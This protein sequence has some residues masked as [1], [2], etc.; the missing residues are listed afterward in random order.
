MKKQNNDQQKNNNKQQIQRQPK[1]NQRS[2]KGNSTNG[3][4]P[5]KYN[6]QFTQMK[7]PKVNQER[8]GCVIIKHKEY[9]T[10]INIVP[11]LNQSYYQ[12]GRYRLNPASTATFPWL[13]TIAQAFE[14]YRFRKLQFCYKP[15]C[16]STIDGA[17]IM[18]PDYDAADASP[19]SE[20]E[21]AMNMDSVEDSCS[22]TIRLNCSNAR[23][24]AAY[25]QHYTASDSRFFS[26]AQD[27]KTLDCGSVV[28]SV[29]S[30][31]T[32]AALLV[33]FGKLWVEYEV[34]L[35]IPQV[36]TIAPSGGAGMNKQAGLLAGSANIF[37]DNTL[38]INNQESDPVI[39]VLPP[40]SFPD[41]KSVV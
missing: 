24:N 34:E 33:S 25:K 10:G 17:V 30:T 36:V 31:E 20:R 26:S 19:I 4:I 22:K 40:S 7:A 12:V 29:I 18:A 32:S 37:T 23:M 21:L 41:R 2:R 16:A 11:V 8:S 28:V 9:I 13:S 1:S 39:Q 14:T 27:Q 35:F 3:S 6:N 5:V 38:V 15:R